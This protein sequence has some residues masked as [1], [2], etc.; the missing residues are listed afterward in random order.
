ML[1][2]AVGRS[3]G[4][5]FSLNL[6]LLEARA[7]LDSSEAGLLNTETSLL[8]E[9]DVAERE[10]RNKVLQGLTTSALDQAGQQG[11]AA[12]C[13]AFLLERRRFR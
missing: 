3:S 13:A 4:R 5:F 2:Q 1:C 11:T 9:G 10:R 12:N 8:T 6:I 7:I